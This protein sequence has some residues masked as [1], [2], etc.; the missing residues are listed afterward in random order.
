[1]PVAHKETGHCDPDDANLLSSIE[2]A[3]GTEYVNAGG[4]GA[5]V[6]DGSEMND[7]VRSLESTSAIVKI[8]NLSV[9]NG[10]SVWKGKRACQ[11]R[12]VIK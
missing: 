5:R 3:I 9:E 2:H 8:G 10:R 7:C 6:R 1:M 4:I 11:V 12:N